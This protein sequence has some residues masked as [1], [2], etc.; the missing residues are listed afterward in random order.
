MHCR[1]S[2][3]SAEEVAL[4]IKFLRSANCRH[5]QNDPIGLKFPSFT[6]TFSNCKFAAGAYPK[7]A[8]AMSVTVSTT[9]KNLVLGS[10]TRVIYQGFTGKQVDSGNLQSNSQASLNAK[11]S[12]AYGT[13]VVGGVSPGKAGRHPTLGLPVYD[14][15]REVLFLLVVLMIGQERAGSSC[16]GCIRPG[17]FGSQSN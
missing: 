6:A 9:I 8:L 11:D 15:A 13:R 12:I 4:T 3:A 1:K 10:K 14:T 5:Q 17:T 7:N 2:Q 16:I